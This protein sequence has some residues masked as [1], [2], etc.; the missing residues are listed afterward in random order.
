[1]LY[2]HPLPLLIKPV[3]CPAVLALHLLPLRSLPP[4]Y[5]KCPHALA[6]TLSNLAL[7][8]MEF[9]DAY[10]AANQWDNSLTLIKWGLDWLIKAHVKAGDSP[11]ENAF[12]GQVRIAC[13]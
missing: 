9:R 7:S 10:I 8:M 2:H 4:D 6:W 13:N 11:A 1:M 12:V 3:P 5:L